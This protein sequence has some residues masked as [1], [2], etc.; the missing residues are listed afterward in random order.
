MA[1]QIA[2]MGPSRIDVDVLAMI[3]ADRTGWDDWRSHEERVAC[4]QRIRAM[5]P[6]MPPGIQWPTTESMVRE[7][8]DN[9]EVYR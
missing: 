4:M 8:R 1:D 5:T 7:D 3:R 6:P 2:A 9:H